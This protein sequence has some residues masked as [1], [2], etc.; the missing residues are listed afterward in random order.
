MLHIKAEKVAALAL[1]AV[2]VIS[3]AG[4]TGVP[5]EAATKKVQG[6]CAL[7]F[8]SKVVKQKTEDKNPSVT[9]SAADIDSYTYKVTFKVRNSGKRNMNSISVKGKL[10][11]TE[12]TFSKKKLNSGKTASFTR[13]IKS[14]SSGLAGRKLSVTKAEVVYPNE[15]DV[16]D[17]TTSDHYV[18]V[19]SGW[20]KTN[21]YNGSIPYQI[22]Y[23][24]QKKSFNYRKHVKAV[25][26]KDKKVKLAVDTSH[27]NFN[28]KG[29]YRIYYT[30]TDSR[31]NSS[32]VWA[33]IGVRKA[34]D[35]LDKYASTIL[36]QITSSKWSDR[37][38]AVA[39]YNYTRGHIAYTGS[40]NKSSWEKE[41]VRAI[42][43]GTGD[44]FSYYALARALLTRA[45]IPNIEVTRVKGHGHHWWNMAYVNGGFYHFDTCPRAVGGRFC[46]VTDA[47]LTNY[48]RTRGGNS[49]IWAYSKKPKTP[50]KTLSKI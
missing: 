25:D 6:G 16:H 41:A 24:T 39:I 13:T 50:K 28:K 38:K 32:T 12:Y 21:S 4:Y 46:L 19:I 36:S 35:T 11:G 8:S 33:K 22:V 20:V 45:G 14:S 1:A 40:S 30:A 34:S 48:S 23:D 27:V 2:T 5:A 42:R 26:N 3:T 44:C 49:H 17:F 7:R 31:G 37:K 29:T 47:Q 9:G 18:P 15:T 10:D 43:E